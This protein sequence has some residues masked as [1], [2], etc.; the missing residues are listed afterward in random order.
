MPQRGEAKFVN[1]R[2]RSEDGDDYVS[3]DGFIA[4]G[5]RK[6]KSKVKK[7]RVKV[8]AAK[9]E[10]SNEDKMWEVC[11]SSLLHCK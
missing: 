2:G 9:A 1:K 4:N 11:F 5:A 7:P 3:D 6:K 8:N 10:G